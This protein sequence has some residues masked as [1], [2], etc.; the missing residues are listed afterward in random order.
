MDYEYD[1]DYTDGQ[2]EHG[3]T[4]Y[5]GE[6]ST[7]YLKID[8]I[9]RHLISALTGL[10]SLFYLSSSGTYYIVFL[11]FLSYSS[12]FFTTHYKCRK[13]RS[14]VLILILLCYL[15]ACELWLVDL[16]Q[17][18]K[19]R[20]LQMIIIM[21]SISLAF[22]LDTGKVKAL[23]NPIYYAGYIMCP[24]SCIFGPWI[25]YNQYNLQSNEDWSL[26]SLGK[27][28]LKLV[29]AFIFLTISTCWDALSFRTSH[30]FI[31]YLSEVTLLLSG[32]ST[33]MFTGVTK[34][35]FVEFPRSL[36]NV[37]IYWNIPMHNWLKTYI[38]NTSKRFGN[39]IALLATYAASSL[40]HGISF[41][42]SAVLLSLGVYSYVEF[43]LRKRLSTVFNACVLVLPLI[44]Y[45]ID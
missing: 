14:I 35:A 18:H 26:K 1:L 45:Y 23:P 17:W 29:L 6:L 5:Y 25:P 32:H 3:S 44:T 13:Y 30:Y 9:S 43:M 10:F 24:S 12:L 20:G 38:F 41:Q 11:L 4:Y 31:S 7:Q 19:I 37:V 15:F 42:L 39:F 21:K 28:C 34:P 2:D 27:I 8:G 40:L 33:S 16:K 36:V 22:D